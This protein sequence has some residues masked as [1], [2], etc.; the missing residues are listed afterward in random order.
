MPLRSILIAATLGFASAIAVPCQFNTD[1][2]VGGKCVKQ[3]GQIWG[4]CWGGSPPG[5]R[6]DR[7]PVEDVLRPGVGDTCEFNTD[8]EVGQQCA[9]KPGA[10][11]GVCL[12]R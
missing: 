2:E 12:R 5:N 7:A 10:L 6:G 8:C 11:E 4:I 1:C 3:P 9:K